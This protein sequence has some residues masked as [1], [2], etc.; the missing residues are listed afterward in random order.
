MSAGTSKVTVQLHI[1][2]GEEEQ[3]IKRTVVQHNKQ[4]IGMTLAR[5]MQLPVSVMPSADDP[6]KYELK[7]TDS[8][9]K[10]TFVAGEDVMRRAL[11]ADDFTA[12]LGNNHN[13]AVAA[14]MED[15]L[16]PSLGNLIDVLRSPNA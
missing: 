7:T 6:S 8:A 4:P 13:E 10:A 12:L 5:A 15:L 2:T 14:L 9:P 3:V 1:G 16:R 11:P